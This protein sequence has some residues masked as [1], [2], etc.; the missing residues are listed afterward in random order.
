MPSTVAFAAVPLPTSFPLAGRGSRDVRV[1]TVPTM[2]ANV[3]DRVWSLEELAERTCKQDAKADE[4]QDF[5]GQRDRRSNKRV[6]GLCW[7]GDNRSNGP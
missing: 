3:A 4:G 1:M 7:F 5:H 6:A 2:V